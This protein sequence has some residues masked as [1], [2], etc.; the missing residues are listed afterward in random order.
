MTNIYKESS[1]VYN[2]IESL[3]QGPISYKKIIA[4][5][6]I[7]KTAQYYTEAKL[8]N[9][10]EKKGIG[11][12]STFSGIIEKL[13]LR[14]Y[15][16]KQNVTGKTIDGI[17]YELEKNEIIETEISKEVGSQKNKL[18]IQPL[19]IMV[20]EFLI[21]HFL[22]LFKYDYTRDMELDLDK[23]SNGDT[24][25]HSICKKCDELIKSESN[26]IKIDK[27]SYKIDEDHEFIIGKYGPV[28]RYQKDGTMLFKKV[29]KNID[30]EK[31]KQGKYN[32][33]QLLDKISDNTIGMYKDFP[34]NLKKG[35]YG[36]YIE[37][38]SIKKSIG[39]NKSI[40]LEEAVALIEKPSTIYGI[41]KDLSIRMGKYG[42]YIFHKTEKMSK[43]K[44]YKYK[45]YQGDKN[46]KKAI[47]E[48]IKEKYNI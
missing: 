29:I 25:W 37:Y 44:F 15:V 16:V 40:T 21:K 5:I 24:V 2:Y 30:Y 28:I 23:I 9:L 8:V 18:V 6:I 39:S 45:D 33:D 3:K 48:W 22:E 31:L 43:P 36:Y 4:N 17:E 34:I 10:L 20:V 26:K 27:V 35:K 19:G 41:K 11:R 46:D 14:E 12:P 7:E 47:L 1:N 32:L 42:E 13:K 38:K